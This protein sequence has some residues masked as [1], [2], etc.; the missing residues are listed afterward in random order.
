M[1]DRGKFAEAGHE[2]EGNI[3]QRSAIEP[4]GARA[5]GWERGKYYTRSRKVNGRV[6]REYVGGGLIGSL[7]AQLD[8]SEREQRALSRAEA[9]LRRAE[10]EALAD[11]LLA[12]DRLAAALASAA[13]VAAGFRKHNRGEWRRKREAR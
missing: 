9:D 2:P 12:V 13:L 8:A 3:L 6:V 7:A 1:A 5:M 11:E 4:L 10:A